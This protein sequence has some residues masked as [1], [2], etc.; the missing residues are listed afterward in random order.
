MDIFKEPYLVVADV[1]ECKSE[2]VS[3]SEEIHTSNN[4]EFTNG[5]FIVDND[6]NDDNISDILKYC[7]IRTNKSKS[8]KKSGCMDWIKV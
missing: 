8:V 1:C 6:H 4:L 7:F 2:Y 5:H 3:V